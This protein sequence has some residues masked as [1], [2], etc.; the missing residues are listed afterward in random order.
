MF[1]TATNPFPQPTAR[2]L[3]D[4]QV[5]HVETVDGGLASNAADC[6]LTMC[7]VSAGIV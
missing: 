2:S 4:S 5:T 1:Q 3:G 6:I 7:N